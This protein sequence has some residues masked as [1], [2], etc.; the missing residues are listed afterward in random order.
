MTDNQTTQQQGLHTAEEE[1]FTVTFSD[2]PPEAQQQAAQQQAEVKPEGDTK[3][4]DA[5]QKGDATPSQDSATG[6]TDDT[7][8][9]EA[10]GEEHKP[11]L[12]KRIDRLTKEKHDL[13]R[14]NEELRA[15]LTNDATQDKEPDIFDFDNSDD[16]LKAEKEY[17]ERQNGSQ[18]AQQAREAPAK[19]IAPEVKDAIESIRDSFDYGKRKYADFE[20]VINAQDFY[21]TDAML[22]AVAECENPEDVTYY[23]ATH[24]DETARLVGLSAAAQAKEIGKIE[25]KLNAA[26]PKPTKKTTTAPPPIDP[27]G[28]SGD[29]PRTLKNVASQAEY[30]ALRAAQEKDAVHDGW[31]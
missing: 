30:E 25:A 6:K 4:A 28:G 23:L 7:S 27:V 22:F 17:K 3:Q 10:G 15:K 9:H 8:T 12:Q 21:Q 26:P 18:H 29:V 5:E 2:A 24:K 1:R 31:L 19:E 14:E 11:R 20:Q 16:Y 13:R